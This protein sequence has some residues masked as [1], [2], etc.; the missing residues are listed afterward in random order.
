MNHTRP[1]P[2]RV[3]QD[4]CVSRITDIESALDYLGTNG[5]GKARIFAG[6]S[7][8]SAGDGDGEKAAAAEL[9]ASLGEMLLNDLPAA[10]R[11]AP[12]ESAG[13]GDGA[14]TGE[15]AAGTE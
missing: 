3:K 7:A 14:G 6:K 13:E 1:G 11:T 12:L 10:Q 5:T 9:E 15:E 4:P 8:R 2:G